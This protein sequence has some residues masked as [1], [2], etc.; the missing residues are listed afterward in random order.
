MIEQYLDDLEKRIDAAAEEKLLSEWKHFCDGTA[1]TDLFVPQRDSKNPPTIEWPDIS[2]N[3][4][5][6]N[7]ELMA[8]HQLKLCSD[9]LRNGT[10]QLLNVRCNYG[11]GILPSLFGAEPFIMDETLNTLPTSRP[12]KG[13]EVDLHVLLEQGVPSVRSGLGAN[14]LEMAGHYQSW[15]KPYP[16]IEQYVNIY[17]P[18]L[19]GPMDV[20]E[21]LYGSELFTALIEQPDFVRQLLDL[22]TQTYIA[23]LNEWNRLVPPQDGYATHWTMMHRGQ[24]MLRDDSAMNLSPEMFDEFIRPYDQRL[25]STF[26]GG[27]IHFCGKGDHF[28]RMMCGM[29]NLYA[30]HMSQPEYNDLEIIFR[31]TVDKNIRILGMKREIAQQSIERGRDLKRSVHCTEG[32]RVILDAYKS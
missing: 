22:I 1:G 26:G 25:L 7:Y 13:G 24:I 21:L 32:G 3:S 29:D 19:Q 18:D 17:H 2:I 20:C 5:L 12:M 30:I 16:L 4:T 14:V 28:I 10:G 9:A 15:M 27:A 11:T 31:N 8:I 23:F 6:D